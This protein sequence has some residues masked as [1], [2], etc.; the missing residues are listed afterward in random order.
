MLK[1]GIYDYNDTCMIDKGI[2]TVVDTSG[3]DAGAN[4]INKEVIF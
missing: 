1:S 4:N 3:T 2:I